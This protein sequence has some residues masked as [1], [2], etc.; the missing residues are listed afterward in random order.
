MATSFDFEN[1]PPAPGDGGFDPDLFW[2]K[3]KRSAIIYGSIFIL[4]AIIFLVAMI[5]S[6]HHRSEAADAFAAAHSEQDLQKIVQQFPG[7]TVAAN[8]RLLLAEKLRAD[9]K[10]DA[11]ITTLK[12]LQS[13]SPEYPL[14]SGA[15]LSLAAT[16]SA[17]GKIEDAIKTYQEIVSKFSSSYAA[18][19][20]MVEQASLLAG[21]GKTADARRTYEDV[22]TQYPDSQFS[23]I[24]MQ[25]MQALPK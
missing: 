11:A 20:A 9:K 1:Q 23:Q 8:A 6:Q 22:L 4:A 7:T 3:H 19:I 13:Q 14:L 2:D 12:A 25:Q 10:Y 16:Q 21:E 15:W 5:L 24:A 17:A 18:P